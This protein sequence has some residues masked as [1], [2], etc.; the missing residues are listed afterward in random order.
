MSFT[1]LVPMTRLQ[2]L[3]LQVDQRLHPEFLERLRVEIHADLTRRMTKPGT[4]KSSTGTLDRSVTSY[5]SGRGIVLY[6]P[7][8]Y[9][10]FVE[11]GTKPRRASVGMVG[12]TVS[13]PGVG[14]RRIT[15]KSLMEGKWSYPGTAGKG[16][17]RTSV[18]EVLGR[19]GTLLT[20]FNTTASRLP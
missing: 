11:E 8:D 16:L 20:E 7:L 9:A 6:S 19:A 4:F 14:P 15:W 13:I 12:K 1:Y 3:L 10:R 5:V 17:F 2:H 18:D